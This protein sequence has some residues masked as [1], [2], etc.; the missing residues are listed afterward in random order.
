MEYSLLSRWSVAPNGS[1]RL[2][3][4]APHEKGAPAANIRRN[5]PRF[6]AHVAPLFRR[7]DNIDVS[8]ALADRR[9]TRIGFRSVHG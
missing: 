5:P 8:L 4:R 7:H 9:R 1:P 3:L 6:G 2:Y